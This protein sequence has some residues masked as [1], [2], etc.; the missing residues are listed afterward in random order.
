M[1][2]SLKRLKR[3][4]SEQ[5]TISGRLCWEAKETSKAPGRS[6]TPR[7]ERRGAS[8]EGPF[9]MLFADRVQP[10]H[11]SDGPVELKPGTQLPLFS[12]VDYRTFDIP[13]GQFFPSR[14]IAQNC[15]HAD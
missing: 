7:K 15:Y 11:D 1:L 3:I 9:E 8:T 13:Q 14:I 2:Y 10:V 5:E 6:R 4:R 12:L